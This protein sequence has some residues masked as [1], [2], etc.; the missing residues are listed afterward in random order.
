ML[1]APIR[2][3]TDDERSISSGKVRVSDLPPEREWEMVRIPE[4]PGTAGGM[5]SPMTPRTRAY[6]DLDNGY[7]ASGGQQLSPWAMHRQEK[8][9]WS[10]K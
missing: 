8:L 10:P 3:S 1:F 5:K 9:P 6:N 4:T 2:S 7:G